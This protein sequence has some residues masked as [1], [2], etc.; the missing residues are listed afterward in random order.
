MPEMKIIEGF[1]AQVSESI[2][3][4]DDRLS[5]LEDR[6]DEWKVPVS[7]EELQLATNF[8][9]MKNNFRIHLLIAVGLFILI[10]NLFYSIYSLHYRNSY[11]EGV[12]ISP[13]GKSKIEYT[14]TDPYLHF[15]WISRED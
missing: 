3:K 6:A 10:L 5:K 8:N 15:Y 7:N 14:T 1:M 11:H 13:D 12:I 4:I 9:I 2:S